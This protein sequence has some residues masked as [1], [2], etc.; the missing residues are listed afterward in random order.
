VTVQ[1]SDWDWDAPLI[2]SVA[3]T[4]TVLGLAASSFP[5]IVP[6]M[7]PLLESRFKPDGKPVAEY[8]MG[9]P[10]ASV[11]D[12]CAETLSPS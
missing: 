11:A 4:V 5:A 3:V 10:T 9:L 8:E 12:I 7:T 6:E 2:E 1:L